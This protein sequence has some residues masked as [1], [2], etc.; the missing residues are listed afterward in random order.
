MGHGEYFIDLA[1]AQAKILNG[2]LEVIIVS[3]INARYIDRLDPHIRHVGYHRSGS[4]NN[5]F[6]LFELFNIFLKESPTL[7]HTHFNKATKIYSRFSKYLKSSWVATKHNPRASSSYEKVPHVIAVS[8]EVAKSFDHPN[9][10]IIN[11]GIDI[12]KIPNFSLNKQP[13]Q[14]K[15]LAVGR[16]EK[17]KGFETLISSLSLLKGNTDWV[18]NIVGEGKE[19]ATL[20]KLI[21]N[22]GLR[23]R[24]KLLGFRDDIKSLMQKHD[25]VVVSSKSEGFSLV[26]LE[27]IINCPLVVS[28]PV[29]IAK[30]L[31]PEEL[32]LP[33]SD[34]KSRL[35]YVMRNYIKCFK[36]LDSSRI[37]MLEGFSLDQAVVK[38]FNLYKSVV[39]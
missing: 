4:R 25:L 35:D 21:R 26:I 24:V 2:Q 16:L 27:S 22:N 37:K 39:H 12:K 1:N 36:I 31:L 28:T 15:L 19:R 17:I 7:V 34:Y 23:N 38:H 14:L 33:F 5:P 13:I 9:L 29:G 32:I 18:L 6:L 3:P 30:E 8:K 11:N 20:E 10:T